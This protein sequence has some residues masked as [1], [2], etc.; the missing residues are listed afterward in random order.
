MADRWTAK[1]TRLKLYYGVIKLVV[2]NFFQTI[3]YLWFIIALENILN[4]RTVTQKCESEAWLVNH[5]RKSR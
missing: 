1:V 2:I 3:S 5:Q 4:M